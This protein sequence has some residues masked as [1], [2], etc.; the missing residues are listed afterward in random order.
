MTDEHWRRVPDRA[1]VLAP[2]AT[3]GGHRIEMRIGAG[4]MGEVYRAFDPQLSRPVAIKVLP[5]AG[6]F[7]A[8]ARQRLVR[9][10]QAAASLNHPN[11]CTI[12]EVGQVD[13]E[14]FIVM[15]LVEGR[16]LDTLIPATGLPVDVVRDYARQLADAVAHAHERGIVHRDLKP[17]NVK[18]NPDGLL[19]VLDFG[20]AKRSAEIAADASTNL[21]QPGTVLGTAAYMSPE[22]AEGRELDK[23]T[24]I[25]SYGV[26]LYELLTGRVPFSGDSFAAV[27]AAVLRTEPD[28]TRV[29]VAMRPLLRAASRRTRSGG[30]ETS[31]M[32]GGW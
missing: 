32:P 29:P 3:I 10:A 30:C 14:T 23:R 28:W 6:F 21:T 4:G 7:D 9:E 17:A 27:A 8:A 16:G 20:L 19:K 31:A 13:D 1:A 18:I 24:D 15:E 12:Y 25:W 26:V 2:G 22:Q 5:A 11:I